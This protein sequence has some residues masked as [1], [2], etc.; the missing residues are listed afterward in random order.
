MRNIEAYFI[1]KTL[2]PVVYHGKL[3]RHPNWLQGLIYFR[4]YEYNKNFNQK[5]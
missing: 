2:S 4:N 3:M 5:V 1:Y